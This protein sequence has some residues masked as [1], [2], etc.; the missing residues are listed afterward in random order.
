M[1][2][3]DKEADKTQTPETS[4][5]RDEG[6]AETKQTE[7]KEEQKEKHTDEKPEA[8]AASRKR[9]RKKP[10][11]RKPEP[12]P[13]SREG[14]RERKKIERLEFTAAD[15]THK[16]MFDFPDGWGTALGE[17]PMIDH[18]LQAA[19]AE[20][21][22][23]LHKLLFKTP[24]Q[25]NSIKKNIRRFYGYDFERN[26]AEYDKRMAL[27]VKQVSPDLKKIC[28]V[29]DLEQKGTKEE[30]CERWVCSGSGSWKRLLYF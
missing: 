1:E 14:K 7:V 4:E 3:M 9:E 21:L 8:P 12:A 6:A 2:K 28:H 5:S 13:A 11:E 18:R 25:L 23:I 29:L 17:C 22:K 19:K 16:K 10:A 26:D 20:E 30:L 27:L 24:G 15:L